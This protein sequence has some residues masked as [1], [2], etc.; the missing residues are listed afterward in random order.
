MKARSPALNVS[1]PVSSFSLAI[2]GVPAF[3]ATSR[4]IVAAF[5]AGAPSTVLPFSPPICWAWA[6]ISSQVLGTFLTTSLWYQSSWVLV[7]NG[8]TQVWPL[9][10]A[11]ASSAGITPF[12][13]TDWLGPVHGTIQPAWAN[14]AVQF[15]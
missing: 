14:S 13:A 3:W 10:F 7:V 6:I 1:L 2:D 11:A 15:T 9:Y 8:A 12:S 5:T 4:M